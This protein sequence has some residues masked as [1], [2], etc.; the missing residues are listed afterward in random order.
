MRAQPDHLDGRP[1]W[2]AVGGTRRIEEPAPERLWQDVRDSCGLRLADPGALD[3][4]AQVAGRH[5]VGS[6]VVVLHGVLPRP[7]AAEL[8]AN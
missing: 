3:Q 6:L 7:W 5:G 2:G 4:R 1:G 8:V